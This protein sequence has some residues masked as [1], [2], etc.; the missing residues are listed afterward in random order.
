M[1]I[2]SRRIVHVNVTTSPTLAWVK[3]QFR[4]ATPS[5]DS[6][7][8]LVHDN[9]ATY[10]HGRDRHPTAV[11]QRHLVASVLHGRE[12]PVVLLAFSLSN[13]IAS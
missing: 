13:I 8:F 4:E 9:D 7:H 6:P 1:E 11:G 3:Q 10:G 5:G 2:A 12:Q